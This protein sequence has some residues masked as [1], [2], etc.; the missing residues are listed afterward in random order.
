M[1]HFF[2]PCW[3]TDR[4]GSLMVKPVDDEIWRTEGQP[5]STIIYCVLGVLVG[6]LAISLLIILAWICKKPNK[7]TGTA[8]GIACDKKK[9]P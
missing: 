3:S 9:S 4:V 6:I 1:C 2:S 5:A 8:V 7:A